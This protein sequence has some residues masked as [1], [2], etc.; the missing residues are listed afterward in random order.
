MM[1]M[2]CPVKHSFQ[3]RPLIAV[4]WW[5]KSR[6]FFSSTNEPRLH[7]MRHT[8]GRS[9]V[10]IATVLGHKALEVATST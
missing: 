9:P 5:G 6:D 2:A 3:F 8:V 10:E 7:D 4:W 1:L